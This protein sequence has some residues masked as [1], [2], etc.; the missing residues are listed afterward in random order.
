MLVPTHTPPTPG[1]CA[2][3]QR[4]CGCPQTGP[5]CGH[6]GCWGRWP[7]R[8]CPGVELEE[9]AY[10]EACRQRRAEDARRLAR[11]TRWAALTL[12]TILTR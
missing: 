5:G 10:A 11:R 3:C 12:P 2:T 8:D 4:G 7:T 9:A 6:Y 1:R